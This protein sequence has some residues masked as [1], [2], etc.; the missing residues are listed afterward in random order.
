SNAIRSN[1]P[2]ILYLSRKDRL[3]GDAGMREIE[4]DLLARSR[5]MGRSEFFGFTPMFR[6]FLYSLSF[7]DDGRL[8]RWILNDPEP[9]NRLLLLRAFAFSEITDDE[10]HRLRADKSVLVR[11]AFFRAQVEAG[12]LPERDELVGLA[13][14]PNRSMRELGRFYLRNDFGEEAYTIYRALEGDEFF[15]IADYAREEDAD[16][17]LEGVRSGSRT[18]RFN[19]LRALASAAPERIR[20]LRVPDLIIQNGK[21]RSVLVPLLPKLLSTEEVVALRRPFEESSP[22]GKISYFR[23][24]EKSSFWNF[25][26]EGLSTLLADPDPLLRQMIV[27]AVQSKVAIYD[28]PS[29]QLRESVCAKIT[30]LRESDPKGSEGIS[31]LVE[32]TIG[33][34]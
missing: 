24:L 28:S 6:R 9:F 12:I 15:Y 21:F 11:R 34:T 8:R 32:F 18:T 29:L 10:K 7:A 2:L 33:M 5:S 31:N 30:Q 25:V 26:D 20:E 17:F 14:D 4:H 22:Q 1:Q 16:H 19:C 23:V 13:V 27:H 3:R